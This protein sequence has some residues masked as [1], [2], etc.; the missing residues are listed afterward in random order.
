MLLTK[1]TT[2]FFLIQ[3]RDKCS[4]FFEIIKK[5]EIVLH[6]LYSLEFSFI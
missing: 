6:L 5:C 2:G 1:S 4:T 3:Q